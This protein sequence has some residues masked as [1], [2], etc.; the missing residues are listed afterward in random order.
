MAKSAIPDAL[1]RRHLMEQEA[2]AKQSVALADVYLAEGRVQ[3]S[4][5]FLAKAEA[6]GRLEEIGEAAV[7]EGDAFLLK[8]VGDLLRREYDAAVWLSLADSADAHGKELYAE[9]AR[10]HAR[11]SEA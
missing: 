4:L 2:D 8:Q 5:F 11:S 10:R 9:V 7:T 3:E 6:W 1:K